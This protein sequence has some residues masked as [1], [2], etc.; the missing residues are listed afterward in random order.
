MLS[1]RLIKSLSCV[2]R[3]ELRAFS[4]TTSC[5]LQQKDLDKNKGDTP[6]P[7]REHEEQEGV[8]KRAMEK[9]KGEYD[10]EYPLSSSMKATKDVAKDVAEGAKEKVKSAY[11]SIKESVS[12]TS[13]EAQNRGESMYGKTKE[14]VS[15]T[16]NKAKEKA[17]SMYDTAKETAKSGADKM[18]HVAKAT[19]GVQAESV[20]YQGGSYTSNGSQKSMSAVLESEGIA[21]NNMDYDPAED[22]DRYNQHWMD[23]AS[24]EYDP[25]D[26]ADRYDQHWRDTASRSSPGMRSLKEGLRDVKENFKEGAKLSWED[27][28]E[29]YKEKAGEIKERIQ[30]TAESMKERMGETGHNMKEKMQQTGQSMKEGMKDSWES[31]KD[32]AKQTKEGAQD[33]WNTAKDKTKEV[34]DAAS[35]KM[36]NS[37]DKTLKRGEKVSERVTEMYSG[38]KGDSK[39]GSGFNQITPEQTENMKGQQSAS[40]AHDSQEHPSAVDNNIKMNKAKPEEDTL[41]KRPRNKSY[42][43]TVGQP[44][45][46]VATKKEEEVKGKSLGYSDPVA[47]E[48]LKDVKNKTNEPI[49]S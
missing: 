25:A 15:D 11:E 49:A 2:S 32:T 35:E 12:S 1:K 22:T 23:T 14:T 38:T 36:S 31:L 7:S 4:G 44:P 37:V 45:G 24:R 6:P 41:T 29:T 21:P 16:A 27:T 18:K 3:T 43:E 26:D 33:Q 5:C 17:E 20:N 28:K 39:G 48:L 8:F 30:D 46:K 9:A 34:K 40:G 47:K 13:S 42:A 19:G 10:P